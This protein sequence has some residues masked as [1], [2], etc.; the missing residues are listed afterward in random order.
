MISPNTQFLPTSPL[1]S[2]VSASSRPLPQDQKMAACSFHRLPGHSQH[3]APSRPPSVAS[4]QL[5]QQIST[6]PFGC[7]EPGASIILSGAW[8]GCGKGEGN[9]PGRPGPRGELDACRQVC[10]Q[11]QETA[12]ESCASRLG[13]DDPVV[14]RSHL[15]GAES[16]RGAQ[17]AHGDRSGVSQ[18]YSKVPC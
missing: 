1:H 18:V 7:L 13:G 3:G 6:V 11:T 5:P 10:G 9:S 8:V 17:A 12:G 16:H 15:L 2:A 14:A 4:L